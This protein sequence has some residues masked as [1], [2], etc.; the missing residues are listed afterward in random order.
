[1][2]KKN[3]DK[4][5]SIAASKEKMEKWGIEPEELGW[6]DG[7]E[8]TQVDELS[9][10]GDD[11]EDLSWDEMKGN[12]EIADKFYSDTKPEDPTEEEILEKAGGSW[13][14]E[15]SQA[16][17]IGQAVAEHINQP[18]EEQTEELSES[19]ETQEPDTS[20]KDLPPKWENKLAEQGGSWIKQEELSSPDDS[21]L[22][23]VKSKSEVTELSQD[24]KRIDTS[25]IRA[26]AELN[27]LNQQYPDKVNILKTDRE[28]QRMTAIVDADI[29]QLI[30]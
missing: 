15:K 21:V 3:F 13:K 12:S 11:E 30:D 9:D 28:N 20:N 6:K 10:G 7:E 14:D 24:R 23:E 8:D 27:S 25:S 4:F 5:D 19:P 17:K 2:T 16:E 26:I 1:M 29:K 18:Q 22:K